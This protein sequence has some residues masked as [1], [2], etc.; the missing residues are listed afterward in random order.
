[1][2]LQARYLAEPSGAVTPGVEIDLA[3]GTTVRSDDPEV[4]AALST[5]LDRS[6]TLWPRQPATD[7]DHYRRV[8]AID[9]EDLRRQLALLPDDPIPDYST[10]TPPE[11]LAELQ[12]YVA[13]LGTYFDGFELHL[14]TTGS[15][16]ALQ[17]TVPECTIDVRRFR[18]NILVDT[19]TDPDGFPEFDWT[20]RDVR[21]GSLVAHVV[22]PMSRCVM[23]TLPQAELPSERSIM[24]TL[25][26]ATGMNLG[27]AL[28]VVEPGRIAEGDTVELVG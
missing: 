19:G 20:G 25:I 12:T 18:P 22:K 11:L 26:R 16:A 14:L 1:V 13:P 28:T 23:V 9:E 24:R 7:V 15:L 4:N 8:A 27:V 17:A 2:Q 5:R 6:V 3:D 21:I 10:D